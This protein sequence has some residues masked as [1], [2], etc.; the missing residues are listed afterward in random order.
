METISVKING[1]S[2]DVAKGSTVLEAARAAKIDIPTLC[3]LK[4]INEIGAC[5]LCLV[6]VSE[7]GR[8]FRLVTACVYPC[9]DGM[10]VLTNTPRINK[11]R[12]TNLE[13]ILSNHDRKCLSC[14]RS[15]TCELQQLCL[16]YGVD[17]TK[18]SGVVK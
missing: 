16:E 2:Y 7:G 5:R 11:S 3:Y 8:P 12:K 10:E 14:V 4:D 13:L 9:T 18:F 1:V 15:T 17:E 6:E